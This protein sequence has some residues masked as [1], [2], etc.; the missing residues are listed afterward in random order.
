MTTTATA[1]P[2]TAPTNGT[3]APAPAPLPSTDP[4]FVWDAQPGVE[5]PESPLFLVVIA[6]SGLGKTHLGCTFPGP[7][8]LFDTEFRGNDVLRKFRNTE[9][10]WKKVATFEDIRAGIGAAIAKHKTPGTILFDS[11]SDLQLLAEAEVLDQISAAGAKAHKTFHWGPVNKLFKNLFG[12]LRDKGWNA[13]FTARLKEEWKGED[14][15]GKRVPG[16]FVTDKLIYHADFA[17]ELRVRDGK[18]VGKVLK[19][20]AKKPNGYRE[21]LPDEVLDYAGIMA[22][23]GAPAIPLVEKVGSSS[24]KPAAAASTAPTTGQP[25][26]PAPEPAPQT[27]PIA[28]A[29]PTEPAPSAIIATGGTTMAEAREAHVTAQATAH[30]TAVADL[31]EGFLERLTPELAAL[32]FHR[33]GGTNPD[34]EPASSGNLIAALAGL[35]HARAGSAWAE[36]TKHAAALAREGFFPD[37]LLA[38][39]EDLAALEALAFQL[40]QAPPDALWARLVATK[41]AIARGQIGRKELAET[42]AALEGAG[43]KTAGAAPAA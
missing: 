38:S 26:A 8:V 12:F 42:R 35:R 10:Y 14:R 22:E 28:A 24:L 16:G 20:G 18:R 36:A 34:A 2:A 30:A 7:I 11:G 43:A 21:E 40:F 17:V 5:P 25:A 3:P 39:P 31:D 19:N 13:V 33:T 15:T 32:G 29:P 9:R 41:K 6:E 37:P 23:M 1:P 4:P 27:A